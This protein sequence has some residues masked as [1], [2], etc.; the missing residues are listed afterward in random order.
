RVTAR[1]EIFPGTTIKA[2]YGVYEKLGD[3]QTSSRSAGNPR[4]VPER[5]RHHVIGIE[6]KLTP[7]LNVDFQLFYNQKSE[8]VVQSDRVLAVNAGVVDLEK[9]SND[10]RGNAYG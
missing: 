10:G 7:F 6:H 8:L 3:P 9:Y 1:Y 2:A 4:L 5:S